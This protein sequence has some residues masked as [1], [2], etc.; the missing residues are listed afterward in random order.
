[1]TNEQKVVQAFVGNKKKVVEA[2][3]AIRKHVEDTPETIHWGHVGNM[4][5][6]HDDLTEIMKFLGIIPSE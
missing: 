1:M 6:V 4:A 5:A 2:L 3:D